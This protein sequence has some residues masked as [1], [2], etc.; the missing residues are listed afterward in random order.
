MT[1]NPIVKRFRLKRG[2]AP[3]LPPAKPVRPEA[4]RGAGVQEDG[5]GAEPFPTAERDILADDGATAKAL[6]AIRA[7][8]LTA[9]QLRMARNIAQ[10]HGISAASDHEAVLALR[11]R[12]IDPFDRAGLIQLVNPAAPGERQVH[13]PQTVT[14][15]DRTLPGPP[16]YDDARRAD[17]IMK[18]QRDVARRR[19]RRVAAL[20]ARLGAFV[21][22]PT[23]AA[24]IYFFEVATPMYA[25]RSEFVIQ[26][27]PTQSS[28]GLGSLFSG[29]QFATS[30][31]SITV[32]SY[33][34]SR[35]AMMRLD[36]DLGF[37]AHFAQPSIDALQRLAADATNED[38]YRTYQRNVKIGFDP[39][40]G[41]VKLEVIAAD[42]KVSQDFSAALIGYAEEQVDHLTAR[43]RTDQMKG[44]EDSYAAAEANVRAAQERVLE[45]QQ[46]LGVLDPGSEQSVLMSQIGT[47]ETELQKKRLELQQ[48]LD[49]SNPNQARVDGASGDIA[50]L[51]KLIAELRSQLTV[52]SEGGA[53]LAL[54]SGQLRLAESEL[55]NR[56]QL[57]A[58]ALQQMETARIEAN[59][60]VRYLS[61]G[62]PPVAP[63]E[64]T[65]PRAAENTALA[66]LIF[67]GI[68]LMLSLTV[69][70]L[71]EQAA[72]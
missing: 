2:S 12:G 57:L 58:M 64:P 69:S 60:Q 20:F 38:A 19:R 54:I 41:L 35:D 27:A 3:T 66:F 6:A 23:I 24:G 48:L 62:V 39:T 52:G 49:N 37:K 4:A 43:L 61:V 28:G 1:T 72:A 70:I 29:T 51:E 9:R 67:S 10:R 55:L 47:F 22:L 50:R 45:L 31:D 65:Y 13:L 30:Q 44:A 63:D 11:Q 26:Q 7:E 32:Q 18:I 14:P 53:S 68:Y 59:R 33:L 42:P 40:E 46:K 34:L 36:A 21:G 25:T 16:V 5:F 15:K 8:G 56:Q 71:R 17:E